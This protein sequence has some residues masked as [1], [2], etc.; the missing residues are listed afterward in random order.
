MQRIL[1]LI[2][3][4]LDADVTPAELAAQSGLPAAL[5]HRDPNPGNLIDTAEGL[6]FVDFELSRRF[7][8]MFDPCY[9]AT[10]VLSEAF[11]RD[12]LPWQENWPA[13]VRALLAGYDS[14]SPLTEAEWAAAPTIM[15]G[16]EVLSI[17]AFVDS[18]KYRHIFDVNMRMLAWML[19]HPLV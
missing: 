17:A 12:D 7:L 4:T 3:A 19:D 6:A 8:R 1:N 13:F 2:E 9:T 5:I 16:N 18:S 14:V 10:A 11:G 15:L